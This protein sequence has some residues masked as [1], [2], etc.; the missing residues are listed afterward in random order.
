M[1]GVKVSVTVRAPQEKVFEISSNIVDSAKVISGIQSIEPLTEGPVKPGFKWRETRIMFG[2][3]ATEEM[4][5]DAFE[6]PHRYTV[7]AESHGCKYHS[8]IRVDPSGSDPQSC[9][10]SMNFSGEG[11]TF[12]AKLMSAVMGWMMMGS[13]RKAL[14][15]DLEDVKAAAESAS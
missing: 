10:L 15:K 3:E 12:F 2:K 7:L 6:P 14:Q 11:T 4:W 8:E 9:V 1:A 5:I 13:V